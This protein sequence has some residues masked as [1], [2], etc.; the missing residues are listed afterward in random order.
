MKKYLLY[1]ALSSCF[2]STVGAEKH[3]SYVLSKAQEQF[4]TKMSVNSYQKLESEVIDN[5]E[6][7]PFRDDS[8]KKYCVT[9]KSGNTISVISIPIIGK[10]YLATFC[11]GFSDII[12]LR[13]SVDELKLHDK[14]FKK[15][16]FSFI[17]PLK[18]WSQENGLKIPKPLIDTILKYGSQN[19]FEFSS[20][21]IL[22]ESKI[23]QSFSRYKCYSHYLDDHKNIVINF[24][25]ENDSN[26][27]YANLNDGNNDRHSERFIVPHQLSNR[28]F[29]IDDI[30]NDIMDD[31]NNSNNHSNV[32]IENPEICKPGQI[33]IHGIEK[34]KEVFI[35][36]VT[37]NGT[38]YTIDL[39]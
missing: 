22:Y 20:K 34:D 2:L 8:F 38:L 1:I 18:I 37:K 11:D 10:N 26:I 6:K 27:L 15:F 30:I 28:G 39:F 12:T 24:K 36:K 14:S 31:S 5:Y 23:Q 29:S 17:A 25:N 7:R 9:S 21:T 19:Y 35:L 3:V 4:G 16:A 33:E 13:E 32:V